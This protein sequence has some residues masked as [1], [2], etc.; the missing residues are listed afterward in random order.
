MITR[1]LSRVLFKSPFLRVVSGMPPTGASVVREPTF[2]I[3]D[4]DAVGFDLDHT[5]ARY[6]L[7]KLYKVVYDS[8]R[9]HLHLK[10][11]PDSHLGSYAD[12]IR[13]FQKGLIVDKC[14][15]NILKL[16]DSRAI[17]MGYHGHRQLTDEELDATYGPSRTSAALKCFPHIR[18]SPT[19]VDISNFV[20]FN[21]YFTVSTQHLYCNLVD[22]VDSRSS[23]DYKMAWE[24]L[25]SG[26]VEMY[27]RDSF[28]NNSGLFY[29]TMKERPNDMIHPCSETLLAWI[30]RLRAEG[31]RTFLLSS[32][33]A[34]FVEVLA[35][36]CVG[37]DWRDYFDV[38]LTY[39]RK[40]GYFMHDPHRRPY[41]RVTDTL[42]EGGVL[43]G[44]LVENGVYSQGNW[45][46]LKKLLAR[47]TGK[48]HPRAVYIGDSITDD[49]MTPSLHDCCDTVAIIEELSAEMTSSHE[50]QVYLSSDV[51]G[52]FF[53]EGS[54]SMWADAVSRTA[55]I[56]IPSLEYLACL[57]PQVRLDA[58]DGV[59]FARGFQP[60]KPNGLSK[61]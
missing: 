45:M 13:F 6:R 32:S 24:D 43:N 48:D 29:P 28:Q 46:Q 10:G 2:S 42:K 25:Y 41:Y 53:G 49:V 4:Y 26:F 51:W 37:S 14:N 52:S 34:D 61:L 9:T 40:P 1:C 5:L 21:D 50:A 12:G 31:K 20:A 59:S 36:A 22:F 38:V 17:V 60:Y 7:K 57:P 55:R 44:D 16:D 11:Y 39:A 54:P 58:F 3:D 30:R 47:C 8:V 18:G 56:A 27:R 23:Y 19:K 35:N 15:G 33:N